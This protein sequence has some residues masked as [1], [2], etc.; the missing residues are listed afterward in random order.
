MELLG[1]GNA[2]QKVNKERAFEVNLGPATPMKAYRFR[3]GRRQT[4][5]ALVLK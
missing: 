2:S 4:G 3:Q 1:D 5:W